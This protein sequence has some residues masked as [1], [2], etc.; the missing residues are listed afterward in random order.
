[1][2]SSSIP[3]TSIL[4]Q[5]F[6]GQNRTG[7]IA[8]QHTVP[9]PPPPQGRHT[10]ASLLITRNKTKTIQFFIEYVIINVCTA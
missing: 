9:P 3:N 2:S 7:K 6:I 5:Y 1:M 8:D 4:L 10:N